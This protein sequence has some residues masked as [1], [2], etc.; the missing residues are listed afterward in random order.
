MKYNDL[1]E[2]DLIRALITDEGLGKNS[3]E[4]CFIIFNEH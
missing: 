4:H 3:R 1:K 2:G